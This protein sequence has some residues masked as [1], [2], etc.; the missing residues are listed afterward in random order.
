MITRQQQH[1]FKIL[2]V[3]GISF[4]A[5][6]VVKSEMD[7][8][9]A[10]T[11]E[12]YRQS[13]GSGYIFFEITEPDQLSFTYKANPA[14]FAPSWNVSHS[15]IHLVPTEPPCGCGF[16]QNHNQ[17]EGKLALV[18]RGECS[19]VSKVVRAQAA[20]AVGVIVTDEDYDNDELFISMADDTTEREVHIPAAFV[21]GKN[22][23]IIK[24]VLEKLSLPHATVNIPVN[25]SQVA[26]TKLRQPPWVVW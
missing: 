18:E 7:P 26:P 6:G 23:F 4:R 8:S 25:I 16:I 1:I 24:T 9:S 3:A 11:D 19:F 14:V 22:G 15:G 10:F 5:L 13:L 2:I 17:V 21:L 12:E 20:G